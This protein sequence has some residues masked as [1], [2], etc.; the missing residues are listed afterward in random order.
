MVVILCCA[1]PSPRR[2]D[3]PQPERTPAAVMSPAGADWLER[4]EREAEERPDIVLAEMK[5]KDGDVVGD[6]GAGSGY[7]SRRIAR[8]VA[9]RGRVYANDIQ[10]EMLEILR[11]NLKRDGIT[12]VVPIL[13]EG[14]DPKLPRASLDWILLVD[15]YHE[16]QEPETMLARMAEALK[17]DG[18]VA[19]VEYRAEGTSAMHIRR[20][21][22]MTKDQVLREWTAAGYKLER[23]S[24]ALPSQRM[25]IF[26]R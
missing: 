20:E 6:I 23:I 19:L 26:T 5:L 17:P 22:R 15:V 9:P 25:F 3:A 1:A 4:P 16:F 10:P 14:N 21:H 8:L 18:R 2:D 7:F 24:E 11:D 12:N 13:G